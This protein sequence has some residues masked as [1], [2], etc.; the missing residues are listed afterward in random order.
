MAC[1]LYLGNMVRIAIAWC[2]AWGLALNVF[3]QQLPKGFPAAGSPPSPKVQID[4]SRYYDSSELVSFC[5]QLAAAHPRIVR[6]EALGTSYE[7]R[8]LPCLTIFD[9]KGP[10][11]RERPAYYMDGNIH[12]N[13]VQAAEVCLYTAWYLAEMSGSNAFIDSLLRARV[14]YILPTINP[15][16]RDH[17]L[18]KPNTTHSPRS[19][20]MPRDNDR[21]GLVN[22]DGPDDLDGDGHITQMIRP[23]PRGEYYRDP[24][25]PR[26]LIRIT[27]EREIYGPR[28]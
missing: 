8:P 1:I 11:E 16:G 13:E 25:E 3:G 18:H 24:K 15:D 14:F 17:F 21:D 23:H 26:R 19:G 28:Y 22:E 27:D 6:Y 9:P 10:P 7:G 20:L 12:A 4:W 2:L 5:Q